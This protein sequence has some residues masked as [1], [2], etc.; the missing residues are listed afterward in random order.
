MTF[1][2]KMTYTGVSGEGGTNFP[3]IP[4]TNSLHKPNTGLALIIHVPS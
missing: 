1:L 2:M 4:R 3:S